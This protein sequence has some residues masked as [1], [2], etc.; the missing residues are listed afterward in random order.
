MAK[1]HCHTISRSRSDTYAA[2][3]GGDHTSIH[4]QRQTKIILAV[5]LCKTPAAGSSPVKPHESTAQWFN[6]TNENTTHFGRFDFRY[7]S[8]M[9]PIDLKII[10]PSG[11]TPPSPISLVH[12][13]TTQ[14]K[15]CVYMRSDF[16]TDV[17]TYFSQNHAL[18]SR[19]HLP[20]VMTQDN[21]M[22]RLVGIKIL[23][24]LLLLL[25][26]L[27]LSLLRLLQLLL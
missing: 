1:D 5:A 3:T 14:N 20:R 7:V 19:I 2:H 27:L 8:S 4:S 25:F 24:L 26:L 10:Q 11:Q 15:M 23:L 16:M 6:E 13:D 12:F 18:A 21:V 9:E 22:V 17:F